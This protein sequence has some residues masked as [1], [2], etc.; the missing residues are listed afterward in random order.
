MPH[1]VPVYDPE[2][3]RRE[4]EADPSLFK[5]RRWEAPH[6]LLGPPKAGGPPK[7][8]EET[9]PQKPKQREGGAPLQG[10]PPPGGE[11]PL[12][13]LG[14]RGAPTT[15]IEIEAAPADAAE[16]GAAAE[17]GGA[18]KVTPGERGPPRAPGISDE[19][20]DLP[21]G[22]GPPSRTH[23]TTLHPDKNASSSSSSNSSSSSSSSSDASTET[24]GPPLAQVLPRVT[25]A[26]RSSSSSSGSSSSSSSSSGG[27]SGSSSRK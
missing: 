22:G 27:S 20:A 8:E 3:P 4:Q 1:F 18:P 14:M 13:R 19:A 9:R 12:L 23:S 10:G 5:H 7:D 21:R 15:E 11:G 6:A 26:D 25:G 24:E 17:R 16:A 2:R